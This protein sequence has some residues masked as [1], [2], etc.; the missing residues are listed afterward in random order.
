MMMLHSV[1]EEVHRLGDA[2]SSRTGWCKPQWHRCR[3]SYLKNS[4]WVMTNSTGLVLPR[5]THLLPLSDILTH[6]KCWVAHLPKR[7]PP[8]R[9]TQAVVCSATQHFHCLPRHKHPGFKY[10]HDPLRCNCKM[11]STW[12][13]RGWEAAFLQYRRSGDHNFNAAALSA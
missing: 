10:W 1:W 9:S 12:R 11:F 2:L 6:R 8:R 7:Q 4:V 3:D 5:C 13:N